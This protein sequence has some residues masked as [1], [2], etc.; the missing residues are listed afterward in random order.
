MIEQ[1]MENHLVSGNPLSRKKEINKIYKEWQIMLGYLL[2]L[3]TLYRDLQIVLSKT[4][5]IGDT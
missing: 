2:V 5:G 3:V 4:I 1:W